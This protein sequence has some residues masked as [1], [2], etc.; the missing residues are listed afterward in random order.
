MSNL[1]FSAT[2]V[3]SPIRLGGP[4]LTPPFACW[5]HPALDFRA[6]SLGAIKGMLQHMSP[7]RPWPGGL[8]W[9]H[10]RR[11]AGDH[12]RGTIPTPA[13]HMLKLAGVGTKPRLAKI[14]RGCHARQHAG[15]REGHLLS[16][17]PVP[18]WCTGYQLAQ[19]LKSAQRDLAMCQVLPPAHPVR[20]SPLGTI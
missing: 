18:G 6:S 12:M 15:P 17:G 3:P 13:W 7:W 5:L 19:G 14:K 9:R 8:Q 4:E 20:S 10:G 16:R 1:F 2:D 11:P